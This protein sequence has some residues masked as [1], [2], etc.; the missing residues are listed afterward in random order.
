M[1]REAKYLWNFGSIWFLKPLTWVRLSSIS[2][3]NF[4]LVHSYPNLNDQKENPVSLLGDIFY[5]C[6]QKLFTSVQID[7]AAVA[8]NETFMA[9]SSW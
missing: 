5:C 2:I 8:I 7:E 6:L 4:W 3:Y 1:R 9:R